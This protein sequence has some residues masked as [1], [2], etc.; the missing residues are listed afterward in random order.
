M[1]VWSNLFEEHID[2]DGPY[3]WLTVK[4]VCMYGYIPLEIH[5]GPFIHE[6]TCKDVS[7]MYTCSVQIMLDGTCV[8]STPDRSGMYELLIVT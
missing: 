8:D 2:L 3:L 1:T 5:V 7:Y 4:T 6:I